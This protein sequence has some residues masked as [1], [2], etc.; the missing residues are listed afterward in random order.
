MEVKQ[1]MSDYV[2]TLRETDSIL[3]ASC[4]MRK[5]DIGVLP[6][7]DEFSQVIGVLTDRDLVIRGLVQ[8]LATDTPVKEI[9]TQPVYTINECEPVGAAISLMS[10]KQVRRLPVVDKRNQLTGIISLRNLATLQLTDERAGIALKEISEPS[11]NPN[12][13][14]EVDDF[15]L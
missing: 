14:L 2:Q 6:I 8:E 15:P 7:I 3:K 4:L 11:T 9:M 1:I 13:D 12:R 10:D 5:F